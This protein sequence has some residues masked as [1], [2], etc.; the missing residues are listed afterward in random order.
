[1]E[2]A[3]ELSSVP[4]FKN[5]SAEDI[6]KLARIAHEERPPAGTTIF[7]EGTPGSDMYVIAL[8][9]VRIAKRN[10]TGDDEDIVVL[11]T[12]SY[13]GEVSLVMDAHVRTASAYAQERC[14]LIR[15][16]LVD[17][18]ALCANDA[19]FGRAFYGSLCAGLAKRLSALSGSVSNYRAMWRK[20]GH[21]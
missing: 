8:G 2:F 14:S 4:L 9:T 12:G 5:L 20:H 10:D 15:L 7:A 13:F 19:S 21:D 11:G 18:Q 17:I 3:S 16:A 6:N 1:M